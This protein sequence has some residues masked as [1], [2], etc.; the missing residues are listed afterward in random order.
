MH[1]VDSQFLNFHIHRLQTN[2]VEACFEHGIFTVEEICN[3]AA[4]R[5]HNRE[6]YEWWLISDWLADRLRKH[7]EAVLCHAYGVWWGRTVTGQRIAMDTVIQTIAAPYVQPYT[8][9]EERSGNN[10]HL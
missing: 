7:G 4:L 5:K 6:I 3:R 10:A 8:P 9:S 1:T 2:L